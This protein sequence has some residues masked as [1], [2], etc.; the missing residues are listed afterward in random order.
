MEE[1]IK[2]LLIRHDTLEKEF[3]EFKKLFGDLKRHIRELEDRVDDI[4][5]D[6]YPLNK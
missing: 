5:L 2:Q 3:K 4:E 1:D 6:I